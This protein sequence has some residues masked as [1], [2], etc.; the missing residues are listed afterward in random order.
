MLV[1]MDGESYREQP[2]TTLFVGLAMPSKQAHN[3]P[4][5]SLRQSTHSK[6]V[7]NPLCGVI[8]RANHDVHG[9]SNC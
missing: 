4:P 6:V 9:L 1:L 8:G 2:F 7:S 3:V 5:M